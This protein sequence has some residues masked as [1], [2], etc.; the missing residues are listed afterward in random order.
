LSDSVALVTVEDIARAYDFGAGHP[1]R[2]E[3]V[4]LTYDNVRTLGLIDRDNVR[5]VPSRSAADE[6][7]LAVHDSEF[8]KMV[9]AIDA[10]RADERAGLEFGLGTP[11]DPIF[12]GMHAASAAV[13][14][15]SIVAA[16]L[17]AN[18]NDGHSFNPAGG[19]HHARRREASGFCI[20]NDPAAAI[21]KALELQPDWRVV[22]VDVDVHHGDGVQWIFYD[23]PRV[24][25]ISFHQS[26]RYLY[27]GTGFEDEIGSGKASGTALNIPLLPFTGEDDYLWALERVLTAVGD[28]YRPQLLVTQLG[29]DTHHGDPLAN[30]GLTMT[31]YPPMAR[32]LHEFAH[33]DAEDRW[34]AM[35]GGGYQAE[36]IVPKVWTIHFAEMCGASDLIPPEWLEDRAPD[37]VSQPHREEIER[38]V[39]SVLETNLPRLSAVAGATT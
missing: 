39:E 27:P 25:T 3:R 4:L 23:E 17:V 38:S 29:A 31:A 30:L 7:I 16:E 10:G 11:D 33:R 2:P 12:E 5:E 14:G 15:A 28:A 6:E 21:A 32:L 19:L 8:V 24:L 13:C 22:Y 1:L 37:D 9:R 20:Y 35:G 18:G 34:V 26:G 36:T